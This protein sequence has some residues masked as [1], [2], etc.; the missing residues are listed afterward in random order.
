[1]RHSR[2]RLLVCLFTIA[3]LPVSAQQGESYGK[4]LTAQVRSDK[5]STP[6]N[7]RTYV[8][9]G[10]LRLGLRDAVILTLENNS[11]VRVQETQVETSKFAL[12]GAHAPF[13]PLIT[14]NDSINSSIEPPFA[15]LQ[16]IGGNSFNINFKN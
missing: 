4:L 6:E 1:M 2:L 13:D 15:F 8:V 16:G 3:T 5:L 12:L 10:K 7:L 9:D 11:Q 14:S